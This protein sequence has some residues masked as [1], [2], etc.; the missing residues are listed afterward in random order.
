MTNCF[1]NH[2]LWDCIWN[3][4]LVTSQTNAI[5]ANLHLFVQLFWRH[6]WQHT[7]DKNHR[8]AAY[9]TMRLFRQANRRH[10]WKPTLEKNCTNAT[11]GYQC[12][13]LNKHLKKHTGERPN[14]CNQCDYASFSPSYLKSNLK[15]HTGEKQNKCGLCEYGSIPHVSWSRFF[16][17]KK[18]QRNCIRGSFKDVLLILKTLTFKSGTSVRKS[19]RTIRT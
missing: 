14:K 16:C 13:D 4:T 2:H 9:V 15:I 17:D 6:T 18:K 19:Y 7:T 10:I 11:T 5:Y 8:N 12:A 1:P 3:H